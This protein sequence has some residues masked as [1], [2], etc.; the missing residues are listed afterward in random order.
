MAKEYSLRWVGKWQVHKKAFERV[1]WGGQPRLV[2]QELLTFREVRGGE[3]RLTGHSI[4]FCHVFV[5]YFSP[6]IHI[7]FSSKHKIIHYI[8]T[9]IHFFL[10]NG[11]SQQIYEIRWADI[12]ISILLMRKLWFAEVK[13]LKASKLL[14]STK[15]IP[16]FRFLMFVVIC[17]GVC[18]LMFLHSLFYLRVFE[19]WLHLQILY[20]PANSKPLHC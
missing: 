10:S 11:L 2:S 19:F 3:L 12:I 8:F 5:I 16:W 7:L 13:F 20:V 4:S 6:L 1:V 9:L 15:L 14:R 17:F 18:C